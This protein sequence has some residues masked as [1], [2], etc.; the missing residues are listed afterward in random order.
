LGG[1]RDSIVAGLG[2]ALRVRSVASIS[3][4]PTQSGPRR[5]ARVHGRPVRRL[6]AWLLDPPQCWMPC[7]LSDQSCRRMAGQRRRGWLAGS[8][9]A[10]GRP[11]RLEPCT[12]RR[13]LVHHAASLFTGI[14]VCSDS[15]WVVDGQLPR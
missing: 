11:L 15:R 14:S 2:D 1:L 10:D 13:R 5:C 7:A 6:L 3:D 4:C 8:L 9:S 12:I